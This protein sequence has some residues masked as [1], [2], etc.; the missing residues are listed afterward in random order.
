[1]ANPLQLVFSSKDQNAARAGGELWRKEILILLGGSDKNVFP[2]Q[3][4]PINRIKDTYRYSML[5][6]SLKGKRALFAEVLRQVKEK[7][8]YDRNKKYN[9]AI[10]Y[11]PYS[12][13]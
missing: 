2:L 5:I 7:H 9:V 10:D 4:A 11:N 3:A 6:K 8:I 1:M 13:L 12:F